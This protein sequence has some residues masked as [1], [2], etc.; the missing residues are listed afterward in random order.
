MYAPNLLIKGYKMLMRG[1]S[2]QSV[3]QHASQLGDLHSHFQHH[4]NDESDIRVQRHCRCYATSRLLMQHHQGGIEM[5]RIT[6][7]SSY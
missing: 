3:T 2:S 5:D 4:P 6:G 1:Y 7:R